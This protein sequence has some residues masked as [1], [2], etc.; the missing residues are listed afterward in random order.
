MEAK[1]IIDQ[2]FFLP[3]NIPF[4]CLRSHPKVILAIFIS[5]NSEDVI[6]WGTLLTLQPL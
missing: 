3:P 4:F 2:L 5:P 6:P 1:L